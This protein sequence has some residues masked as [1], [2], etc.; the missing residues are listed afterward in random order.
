MA[1][2]SITP[3]QIC[4]TASSAAL[5]ANGALHDFALTRSLIA[6]YEL[7]IAVDGGLVHCRTMGIVPDLIIGDFDSVPPGLTDEYPNTPKI[8]FST[9]KDDTDLELA[10]RAANVP[11]MKKIGVFA[12]MEKQTDHALANLHLMR[13]YPGKVVIETEKET[14]FAI[15]GKK[16][17]ECRPGQTLSLIPMGAPALGVTTHGLKW[18]LTDATVNKD[19]M[20]ISNCCLGTRVE[21]VIA[22]GDL[23]CCL[24]R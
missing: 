2:P 1:H 22:E 5:I 21:I 19:F 24:L 23:I 8:V 17:V 18:E 13:R 20:S 15:E 4:S 14:I 10:V 3:H 6:T 9:D 11:A 16:S 12:A 7:C